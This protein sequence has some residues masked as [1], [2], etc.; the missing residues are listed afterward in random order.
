L[1][2]WERTILTEVDPTYVPD[3]ASSDEEAIAKRALRSGQNEMK[4]AAELA[5]AQAKLPA[6]KKK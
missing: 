4:A 1:R 2:D 6:G 5:A 3:D